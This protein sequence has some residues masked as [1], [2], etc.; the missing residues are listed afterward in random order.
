MT[1]QDPLDA[2]YDAACKLMGDYLAGP[3]LKIN[4]DD[5]IEY[6]EPADDL[7]KRVG[8][9]AGIID[10]WLARREAD[11]QHE[12]AQVEEHSHEVLAVGGEKIVICSY[13]QFSEK[14]DDSTQD[15]P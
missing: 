2:L 5:T 6:V 8:A 4:P 14:L 1:D 13:C 9:A 7:L 15:S 11:R 10:R 12:L 3:P